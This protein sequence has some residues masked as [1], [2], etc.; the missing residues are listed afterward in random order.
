MNPLLARQLVEAARQRADGQPDIDR[1]CALVSDFYDSVNA[2]AENDSK[3]QHAASSHAGVSFQSL[4]DSLAD[5]TLFVDEQGLVRLVNKVAAGMFACS[6]G[7]LL[8]TELQQLLATPAGPGTAIQ[9]LEWLA[10]GSNEP[11]LARELDAMRADGSVFPVAARVSDLVLSGERRFIVS[12]RDSSRRRTREPEQGETS[13]HDA[14]AQLN[15]QFEMLL[16]ELCAG[17]LDTQ[18]GN[19]EPAV[20]R[21]MQKICEFGSASQGRI[22]HFTTN[23]ADRADL[24]ECTHAW[25][26]IAHH[27]ATATRLLVDAELPWLAA[28]IRRRQVFDIAAVSALP[29]EASRERRWFEAAG[30]GSFVVVP[31][32]IDGRLSGFMLFESQHQNTCWPASILGRLRLVADICGAE[33]RRAETDANRQ[34]L[35]AILNGTPDLVLICDRSGSVLQFNRS[36]EQRLGLAATSEQSLAQLLGSEVNIDEILQSA[37]REGSWSGEVSLTD[38][39]GRVFP[40]SQVVLAHRDPAGSIE[41]FSVTARDISHQVDTANR[42]RASEEHLRMALQAAGMVTWAWDI[43]SGELTWS[44]RPG[45]LFNQHDLEFGHHIDRYLAQV[46]DADRPVLQREMARALS[47]QE[48]YFRSQHRVLTAS[49]EVTWLELRARIE[50]DTGLQPRRMVGTV[51]DVSA[52]KS[53]ELA[54][55]AEKE[56]ALVTLESIADAVVTTDEH[57]LV[58]SMNRVAEQRLGQA[59]EKVAGKLIDQL[60]SLLSDDSGQPVDH[61]VLQC[62]QEERVIEAKTGLVLRAADGSEFA[63]QFSAAPIRDYEGGVIGSVM[64]F[65]DVSLERS[66]YQRLSYQARHDALTGLINR[67]ELED[68]LSSVLREAWHNSDSEHCL[69]YLDLDQFKVINDTCGHSA[70]D[71]LLKRVAAILQQHTRSA[72]RLARLGGDEF[73]ILLNDCPQ[74]RGEQIAE[75]LRSAISEFRFIWRDRTFGVSASI[76]LVRIDGRSENMAAVLSAADVACYA[77]KEAGRNR[78]SVYRGEAALIQHREMQWVSRITQAC[79]DDRLSLFYHPIVAV[80]G[81]EQRSHFELLLR[82]RDPYGKLVPPNSFIPAAERYNLMPMIDRWV[83]R[84]ALGELAQRADDQGD[85]YT[86]SINLSGSSLSDPDFLGFL[87]QQMDS[88]QLAP[89]AV[90]FEITETSAITNLEQVIA[91]M[92]AL[93]ELGC[94][95]SLDDFGSGLSSFAYLKDLPVDFLKIDRHFVRNIVHDVIDRSMVAAINQ[96]GHVMGL[97]TIAEGVESRAVY[98]A[99]KESGIDLAQG[100]L[101]GEPREVNGRGDFCAR[102]DHK[103]VPLVG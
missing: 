83:V 24:A 38:S 97:R 54:L 85:A 92:S 72:D 47:G 63:V 41:Y 43:E 66:L 18:S 4:I 100:F 27:P 37:V 23:P 71:E 44:Q 53:A 58:Q 48:Q 10:A 40:V 56:R 67:R 57:G 31:M 5:A 87:A 30:V 11:G 22:F 32:T 26:H 36:A 101:F 20:M 39:D 45:E 7:Q 93:R 81:N 14:D 29:E 55:C 94:L 6:P 21:A 70:G 90:C 1:L 60:F 9:F 77:A 79:E 13:R 78:V 84:H 46:H 15:Q 28:R 35:M 61:P 17:L 95:F 51:C 80:H 33:L 68:H 16:S 73:C 42:L 91:F 62:L 12:L 98:E 86:L 59:G 76:G 75:T 34:R 8:H 25:G 89:G 19:P 49:G 74:Q 102:S 99:L 82:M 88:H 65:H 52:R 50:R 2:G 3:Q 96:V 103:V 69:L 64:V